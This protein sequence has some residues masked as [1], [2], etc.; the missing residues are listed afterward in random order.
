[1][2]D[3]LKDQIIEFG[4]CTTHTRCFLHTVNLVAI[5]LVHEFNVDK[6]WRG[7]EHSTKFQAEDVERLEQEHRML[8]KGIGLEELA[9]V[10]EN[11]IEGIDALKGW[12]D[13]VE[14]LSNKEWEEFQRI[15][16]LVKL[17]LVKLW[18]LAFKI[19]HS[20]TKLLPE[21]RQILE[22]LKQ[23]VT[24]LPRDI[25]TCWNSTFNMLDYALNHQ[26]DMDT[27]TQHREMGLCAF[28]LT[29]GE[30]VI[31]KELQDVLKAHL[32]NMLQP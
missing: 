11:D 25:P 4:G 32:P 9:T 7:K 14:R 2:I 10:N 23:A 13:Q 12:I 16:C 19:V 1:M 30:W 8:A 18:Q 26:Q 17:A 24:N 27:M 29:D 28:E 6:K 31:L 22:D 3:K 21:W 20:T 15:I 5:S